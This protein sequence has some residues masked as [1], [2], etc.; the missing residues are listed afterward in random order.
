MSRFSPGELYMTAGVAA[1]AEE[2]GVAAWLRDC[3]R[4]HLAGDWGDVDRSDRQANED[5]LTAGER[6]F[7]VYRKD[8]Y[9]LYI[10][11]EYDRS[12]TTLLLSSE[13]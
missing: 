13:Y 2:A 3:I 8:G 5:A 7:S 9:R 1:L 4:R 11:T 6:L 12:A 10:I